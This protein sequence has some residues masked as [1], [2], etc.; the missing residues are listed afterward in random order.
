MSLITTELIP[1]LAAGSGTIETIVNEAA[2]EAGAPALEIERRIAVVCH[3]HPLYGG[4]MHTR[5][6][7]HAAQ[8]LSRMGMPVVRFN[9]RG[10]G[11]ST[12]SYDH[13]RGE[14]D[15]LRAVMN[16]ARARF[17][18]RP[19]VLAGFSFGA[20]V[21]TKL[22]AA[23]APPDVVQAVLLGLPVDRGDLPRHWRWQGPKLMISGEQ[24]EFASTASLEAFF[25]ELDAPKQ[26]VWLPGDHFLAGHMDAFRAALTERL[27]PAPASGGQV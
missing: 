5:I 7:F 23:E 8:A 13:G 12:G 3:P 6:V 27:T 22:L 1:S 24:D 25:A 21:V 2:P 9:F 11:R 14:Q 15:D 17:P 18:S 20:T 4:T 26:R 10:V 19:L 16:F